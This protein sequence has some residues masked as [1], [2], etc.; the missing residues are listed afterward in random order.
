VARVVGDMGEAGEGAPWPCSAPAPV[1]GASA[2]PARPAGPLTW[3]PPRPVK[4]VGCQSCCCGH[5]AAVRACEGPTWSSCPAAVAEARRRSTCARRSAIC[6]LNL[7]SSNPLSL[8][9]PAAW[10]AERSSRHFTASPGFA[11][12]TSPD[13]SSRTVGR[14]HSRASC[15]RVA[16]GPSGC[17]KPVSRARPHRSSTSGSRGTPCAMVRYGY[18][19]WSMDAGD[20]SAVR[21]T[22]VVTWPVCKATARVLGTPRDRSNVACSSCSLDPCPFHHAPAPY[23]A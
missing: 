19:A 17:L 11:R 1:A 7:S 23:I 6:R 20:V 13:S 3:P 12:R 9:A 5:G 14:E 22:A 18:R 10:A 8:L 2:G 15:E 4:V 21:G 16:L